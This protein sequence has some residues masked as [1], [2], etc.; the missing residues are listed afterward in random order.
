MSMLRALSAALLATGLVTPCLGDVGMRQLVIPADDHGRRLSVTLWYPSAPGGQP[1][2]VGDN[3]LFKGTPVMRDAPQAVGRFPLVLLSHGSGGSAQSMSWLATELAEAGFIVAGPDHPGTTSG[4]STPAD[5]PKLWQRRQDLS[6]VADRL[7]TDPQWRGRVDGDRIGVVGFS[8]G[9]AAAMR[10]AGARTT[11]EAYARYCDAETRWDCAWYAG[12]IGFVNGART[13]VDKLNLRAVDRALFEQ[14]DRD[15]R[16]KAAV[17][18]DPG[19]AQAYDERSLA[20]VAIPMSFVNLG[21][22]TTIPP[23]VIADQLASQTP[24]GTYATVT[25][26][27]HYSFLPECKDGA[28]AML[29]SEGEEEPLCGEPGERS[30][31]DIHAE[32]T[33]LIRTALRQGLGPAVPAIR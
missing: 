24:K 2:L 22:P 6:A 9:G 23:G 3:G 21:A 16:I 13:K 18:I 26:A 25:G 7:I 29:R 17:M 31:K 33:R 11:L 20:E 4:D 8:I 28:A 27:H 12:G 15:P 5:T 10:I 14:S 1:V 19:L 32:L 30:R